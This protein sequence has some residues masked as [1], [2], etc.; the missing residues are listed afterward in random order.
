VHDL[1]NRVDYGDR[2]GN[3][4]P[5]ALG[6]HAEV[7]ELLQAALLMGHV[8]ERLRQQAVRDRD[9]PP[10]FGAGFISNSL[11]VKDAC[12]CVTLP[13]WTA[14]SLI[15]IKPGAVALGILIA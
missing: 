8:A 3:S 1:A 11:L 14:P 5:H 4:A 12:P 10:R 6:D 2:D 9:R 15:L 7:L 13:R